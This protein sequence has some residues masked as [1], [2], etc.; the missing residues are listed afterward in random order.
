M[1]PIYFLP[2]KALIQTCGGWTRLEVIQRKEFYFG[3]YYFL[4]FKPYPLRFPA[5]VC[6]HQS[7]YC[8]V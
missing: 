6:E 8:I 5:F 4:V 3:P 2:L 1:T 7:S